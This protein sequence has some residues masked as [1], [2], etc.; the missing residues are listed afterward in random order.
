MNPTTR[1]LPDEVRERMRDTVMGGLEST[2]SRRSTPLVLA[3]ATV[4]LLGVVGVVAT[5]RGTTDPTDSPTSF[6]PRP[7]PMLDMAI[8]EVDLDRCW[9][10]IE[11]AGNAQVYPHRSRW[12]PVFTTV[13]SGRQ[14]TAARANGMPLFCSTTLTSVAV[15]KP[16]PVG[17]PPDGPTALFT[18]PDGVVAGIAP[19]NLTTLRFSVRNREISTIGLVSD[20]MFAV[21]VGAQ[22]LSGL[23]PVEAVADGTDPQRWELREL[24]RPALAVVD[25]PEVAPDR[26][27]ELGAKVAECVDRPRDGGPVFDAPSWR[28]GVLSPL[29]G[30]KRL[31]TIHNSRYVTA[32][33][34]AADG[35]VRF[36]V[37]SFRYGEIDKVEWFMPAVLHPAPESGLVVGWVAAGVARMEVD[38]GGRTITAT[39]A[40]QG[41][42]VVADGLT[43]YD[44][45][46][47]DLR[48]YDQAGALLRSGSLREPR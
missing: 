46:A 47:G 16:K 36:P 26:A 42:A 17:D 28:A 4:A 1:P 7:R 34:I 10:Q 8:A 29:L 18:S 3:A 13:E 32:C 14:V 40:N 38:A 27:T 9:A 21:V 24:P 22:E 41:F 37:Q 43:A 20:G 25:K 31:L 5:P 23:G 45:E 6:G 39:I 2:T 44:I 33:E 30:D 19:S 48:L 11:A 12:K 15:S 35:S